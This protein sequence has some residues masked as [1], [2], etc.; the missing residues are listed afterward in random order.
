[1]DE[2]AHKKLLWL[3]PRL[4][5]VEM[6]AAS[7]KKLLLVNPVQRVSLT[8]SAIPLMRWPPTNLA[9][10]A[11]LTAPD[12]TVRIVDENVEKLTYED[13]DLVG[14]TAMTCNAPRAYDI[15]ERYRK[16]GVKTVIGGV[17]ASMLPDEARRFVD[18]VVVGEPESVWNGL[19]RDFERHELKPV[20]VGGR[21]PMEGLAVARRDL[22]RARRYRLKASVESARGC[23]NNCEFCS[24]TTLHGRTYRQR[25]VDDV[26]DEIESLGCGYFFFADDNV[27]GYGMDAEERAIRLF[28]GM[29]GRGLNKAWA[30]QVGIDFAS[31]PDVLRH[32]RRAGCVGVFIG[33]ESINEESLR[34]MHKA[35]NLRVGVS[36]YRAVV[37]RIHDYGM[38]VHAA[39]VFGADGDKRDTF[40]RTAEFLLDSG[41]DSAQLTI[42]TPLPGTKLYERLRRE[43][44]LLRTDYP[45]DWK[46]YDFAEAVFRPMHMSPGE[47]EEGVYRV[48]TTTTSR[49]VSLRRAFHTFW[50]TNPRGTVIA[51][52]L[53][54]GLGSLAAR[55][56]R[57]VKATRCVATAHLPWSGAAAEGVCGEVD[58]V[59]D[60]GERVG[61]LVHR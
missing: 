25:P 19:L 39:F 55:K 47:L 57:F 24:V 13:A 26:L 12:W 61:Q 33:F 3:A 51:Y 40:D 38:A 42:L 9:Y 34:G 52:S 36:N 4:G 29:V 35:R 60:G 23:P 28:R 45:D 1:V 50:R 49:K 31:S 21:S 18:A 2:V 11:A 46:Y 56:Y 10:L 48:Y 22:Y 17:H 6:H 59:E 54:R 15:S 8:L 37:R 14:V 7:Q 5:F 30:C 32:A 43:G 41:I 44:R 27:L 20:Y 16:K 53:N 58:G